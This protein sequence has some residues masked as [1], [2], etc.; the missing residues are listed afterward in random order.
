[1]GNQTLHRSEASD[2]LSLAIVRFPLEEY[3]MSRGGDFVSSKEWLM[4][5]PHCGREKLTV[6]LDK[7][8]WRCFLCEEYV[9]GGRAKLAKRGA[10][11]IY[12]LVLW[13]EGISPK[14]AVD[15]IFSKAKPPDIHGDILPGFDLGSRYRAQPPESLCATGLPENCLAVTSVLPY[16]FRRGIT[17]DDAKIFGLGYCTS[18]WLANRL[19]FPVWE[20]GQCVYW[21]ARA[22]WDQH[23]HVPKPWI[24]K[25]GTM[26]PDKFRKNLN[27]SRDRGGISYLGS[28]DVLLNLEQASTYK[29]IAITEG[30]TSMVPAGPSATA[31]FGKQLHPNQISR[32]IHY[33]VRGIDFMWDGPSE[34][35]PQ[36]AWPE[37]MKAAY[38]LASFF[39]VKIVFL[40]KGDPGDYTRQEI[41]T[42][43]ENARPLSTIGD[44]L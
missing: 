31:T 24:R 3:V 27:P 14:E 42:F 13:L 36:G 7:R 43:R 19:I 10:G 39:D 41:N 17:L 15:L 4:A 33:G 35:E 23:E 16:M 44:F 30:P 22:M 2:D 8:T 38:Q 28:G 18:G 6:N 12:K 5:C 26:D 1:M 21:Q 37:M 32:M 9:G 29:R 25:D 40:P 20:G 11:G 34:T